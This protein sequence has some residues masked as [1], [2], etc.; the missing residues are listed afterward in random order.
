[1][2][3]K[4]ITPRALQCG[5]GACP[6]VFLSSRGTLFVVGRT[7]SREE[8][9]RIAPGRIA[10]SETMVEIPLELVAELDAHLRDAETS[11]S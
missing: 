8:A 6:S 1:M 4:D 11:A 9:S 7:V 10:L 5:F 2:K 3:V